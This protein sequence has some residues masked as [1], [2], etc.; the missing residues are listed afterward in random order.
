[1][2]VLDSCFL[3][4]EL[5]EVATEVAAIQ[6]LTDEKTWLRSAS[7]QVLDAVSALLRTPTR[8]HYQ[9]HVHTETEATEI[10]DI[11]ALRTGTFSF[12]I[13]DNS[14]PLQWRKRQIW[15]GEENLSRISMLSSDPAW[16]T[17]MMHTHDRLKRLGHLQLTSVW[18][19]NI[20]YY[21]P[22]EALMSHLIISKPSPRCIDL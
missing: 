3:Q 22:S 20:F 2:G 18:E 1:M 6:P 11:S 4:V 14:R 10:K 16:L 9:V 17:P 21:L 8:E 7:N 12:P 5:A 15:S 19:T 13:A